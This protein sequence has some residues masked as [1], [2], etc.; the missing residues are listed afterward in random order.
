MQWMAANTG[1]GNSQFLKAQRIKSHEYLYCP[2]FQPSRLGTISEEGA[3]RPS[4]PEVREDRTT[5]PMSS[6]A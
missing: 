1:A 3:E 4:M 2:L 6:L 5:A